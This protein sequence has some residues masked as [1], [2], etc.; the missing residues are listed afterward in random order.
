MN[1]LGCF[2]LDSNIILAEIFGEKARTGRINV[3]KTDAEHYKIP[4]YTSESVKQEIKE[5]IYSICDFLGRK[6]KDVLLERIKESRTRRK[7]SLDDPITAEDIKVLEDIISVHHKIMSDKYPGKFLIPT[8]LATIEEWII[9]MI[10]EKL[11]SKERVSFMSFREII[12]Q[13][14]IE[15][16]VSFEDFYN[17]LLEFEEG[18]IKISK[19]KPDASVIQ[20]LE[21]IGVHDPDSKHI[22]SAIAHQRSKNEKTV[23]VTIDYRTILS[24]KEQILNNL[25]LE[26]SDPLY[27]IYHLI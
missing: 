21:S 19:E 9:K 14:I 25:N 10:D 8:P 2:F 1:R 7:L 11:R 18:Y 22:A 24:K 4:C 27:A 16:V 5:K 15:T 6:I 3:L 13:K 12:V 17:Y 23:Y 26:C 20:K